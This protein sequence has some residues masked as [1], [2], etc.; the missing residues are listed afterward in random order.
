MIVRGNPVSAGIAVGTAFLYH[1]L[2]QAPEKDFLVMGDEEVQLAKLHSAFQKAEEE[3]T[4]LV[5]TLEKEEPEKAGIFV[6]HKGILQDRKIVDDIT[7]AVQTERKTPDYAVECVFEDACH[8]LEQV[9]D[10]IIASRT[11]DL[12]DVK[13]RLLRILRGKAPV[14]LTNLDKKVI[15]IAHELLPSDTAMLDREHVMGIITE[16]GSTTSHTAIIARS[17]QIPAILGVEQAL[18]VFKEGESIIVDAVN[19]EILTDPDETAI[20]KYQEQAHIFKKK[21]TEAIAYLDKPAVMQDGQK[22]E[23]GI[24]IGSEF[25]GAETLNYDFIGLFRTEF[26]YMKKKQQ[27][28]EEEQFEAY[29]QVLEHAKGKTV[30]LRTLDIGGDKTLPYLQLPKEENPF[31]G[32]RAL[33]F[34]LE[35]EPL[36]ATQ[37]RAALRASVFGDLQL[38]FPMVGSIEDIRAAKEAVHH[39]MEQL[40]K[41]GIAYN[42]EIKLGIMIE[43]PAIALLADVAADEV[44]FASIGTNDL[45]QYLCATDRMDARVSKY[46]QPLSPAALRV[47]GFVFEQFEQKG[48]P[49]SVCG[50]L[51]GNPDA[52]V[53]LVGLG[54]KKLSMNEGNIPQVKEALAGITIV[55]AKD[56]ADICK[57]MRTEREV[58]ACLS[59]L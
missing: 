28:T 51:A 41:E 52:A 54:A 43:I 8:L 37:L 20:M 23:I 12:R 56:M 9:K 18:E 26:L 39:A 49:V 2:E 1:P 30:T 46:Y 10:P 17:Y 42:K 57:G 3:L 47:L 19:G 21:Q 50:E 48:K 5:K 25:F 34:C 40:N 4:Y 35:N 38:M 27:P 14:S 11:A 59:G 44:D 29:R 45:T 15:V 24:N 33:R 36:F 7:C 22:I 58:E 16:V 32:K 31:L 55:K 53:L 13:N 6:A